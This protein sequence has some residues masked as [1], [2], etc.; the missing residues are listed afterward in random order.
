MGR[1]LA[2]TRRARDL[3]L[4]MVA[5]RSGVSPAYVSQIESGGANP[6]IGTLTRVAAAVGVEVASLF[7]PGGATDAVFEPYASGAALAQSTAGSP[8]VWDHSAP[9]S[10]RLEARVVHGDA[11]DHA[12]PTAHA[13]EE[14]VLVLHGSCVLDVD[15]GR[16]P[17]GPGDACHFP[18]GRA[19]YLLDVS[20]E[21]TLSVVMSAA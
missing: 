19:H 14:Y 18:A 10:A 6:T 17:L 4:A 20:P 3:T 11:A 1:R 8:G 21:L 5:A 12:V 16:F 13:G 7:V 9:G 2:D 15:G